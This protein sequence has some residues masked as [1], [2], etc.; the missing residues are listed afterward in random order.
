MEKRTNGG[1]EKKN[2]K[3]HLLRRQVGPANSPT[4][5]I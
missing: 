4:F 1:K 3:E 2:E 5:A